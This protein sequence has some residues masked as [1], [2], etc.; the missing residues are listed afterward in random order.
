MSLN[1]LVKNTSDLNYKLKYSHTFFVLDIEQF[2][3]IE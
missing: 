2:M 1:C 3:K